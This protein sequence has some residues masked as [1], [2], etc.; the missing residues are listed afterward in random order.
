MIYETKT[1]VAVPGR[2]AAMRERFLNEARPRL[3]R[4][5]VAVLAMDEDGESLTYLTRAADADALAAGWE[6]FK[7]DPGWVEVKARSEADGPLMASQTS[8]VLHGIE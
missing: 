6:A 1:Y 2:F 5:G 3:E 4:H 7:A 8:R